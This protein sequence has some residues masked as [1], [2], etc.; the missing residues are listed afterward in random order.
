MISGTVQIMNIILLLAYRSK[1]YDRTD[2][3]VATLSLAKPTG[4]RP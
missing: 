2:P 4:R 3:T 1:W